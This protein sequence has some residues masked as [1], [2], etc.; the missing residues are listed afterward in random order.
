[1]ELLPFFGACQPGDTY[2]YNPLSVLYNI[3]GLVDVLHKD[4]DHLYCCHLSSKDGEG[5]QKA[6]NNV[7]ALIIK[8]LKKLNLLDHQETSGMELVVNIAL[9]IALVRT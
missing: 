8:S 9:A 1:M 2:Y 3:A 5:G 6:G 7:A 4:G